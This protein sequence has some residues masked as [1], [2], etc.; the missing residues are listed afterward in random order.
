[1]S[2]KIKKVLM[3]SILDDG[4]L[5]LINIQRQQFE[6]KSLEFPSG[7]VS[8]DVAS[9]EVARQELQNTTGYEAKELVNIG[10]FAPQSEAT[11]EM[12]R[13]FLARGLTAVVAKPEVEQYEVVLR[14]PDEIENLIKNGEIF[15]GATLS[16]WCF[17]RPYIFVP[18]E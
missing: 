13:V 8:D 2:K 11:D 14:R 1:M 10:E 5:I 18:Q 6:K 16:A 7:A 4:R 9:E 15:D 3:V 17:A 12:C